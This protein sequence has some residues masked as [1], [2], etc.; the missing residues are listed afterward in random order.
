[1]PY[2]TSNQPQPLSGMRKILNIF[3]KSRQ[4]IADNETFVTLI[5]VAQEDPE[6]K[7]QLSAILRLDDFNRKS[8][9]NTFLQE[10]QL[11]QAPREFVEVAEKVLEILTDNDSS[12]AG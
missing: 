9:L 10:M 8:A 2:S 1:M 11:K 3:R 5:R 6:V 7:E 12:T 4:S